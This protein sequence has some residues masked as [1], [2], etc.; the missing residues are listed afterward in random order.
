M[1]KLAK[2][3]LCFS[4]LFILLFFAVI[5]LKY[6]DFWISAARI[7]PLGNEIGEAAADLAWKA[8]P[9][10]LYV[11]I[12]LALSYSVRLK[13]LAPLAMLCIFVVGSALSIGM[14][15]GIFRADSLK[16]ALKPAAPVEGRPGLI[17]TQ[18]DNAIILLKS[19]SDVLG[20]RVVSIPGLPLNYQER[21]LGPNN[22]IIN[23]PALPFTGYSPW[24]VQSVDIDFR[25][26]AGEMEN[27]ISQ[28]IIPL[29]AYILSLVLLLVSLH[30]LLKF[31]KWPLAN[32]F[33]GALAFRMILLLETFINTGEINS[34]LV[35]FLGNR[36]S[37]LLITPL[38]FSAL[39][40]LVIIYT[41][42]S[43]MARA[44]KPW[45]KGEDDD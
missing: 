3:I 34:L 22:T 35:S 27:R 28:G 1:K 4:L 31:S 11:S 33:F 2:L 26:S 40:V 44:L 42:L 23:L 14:A 20:P 38:A 36:L 9:I 6:L 10:T 19:S 5:F 21:P 13:I 17:L 45:P 32:L 43:W 8:L 29:G 37:P 41:L 7:I 39:G 12:L 30:F 18:S 25:L 15:I 24:F 16:F